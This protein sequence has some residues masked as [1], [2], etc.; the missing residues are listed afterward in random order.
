MHLWTD[1]PAPIE[2]IELTL[3][4]E[5]HCLPSALRRERA[6]DLL[7]TLD[8]LNVEA[9]VRKARGPKHGK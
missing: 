1:G 5:Y 7:R 9:K 8:M 4:R 3:C 6:I 2:Y